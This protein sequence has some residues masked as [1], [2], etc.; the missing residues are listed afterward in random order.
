MH[1]FVIRVAICRVSPIGPSTYAR[2]GGNNNTNGPQTPA[3]HSLHL[4]VGRLFRKGAL[5]QIIT[6]LQVLDG[7]AK[8]EG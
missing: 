1:T 6:G 7:I 8:K 3:R 2:V 5:P 4:V